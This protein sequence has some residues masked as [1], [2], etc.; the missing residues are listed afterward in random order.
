VE[1][2]SI[3]EGMLV[4]GTWVF[5]EVGLADDLTT[6]EVSVMGGAVMGAA[7]TGIKEGIVVGTL[8]GRG[9]MVLSVVATGK[10]DEDVEGVLDSSASSFVE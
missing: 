9:D 6:G 1:G 8:V 5:L 10:D 2:T 7:V 3:S 4:F